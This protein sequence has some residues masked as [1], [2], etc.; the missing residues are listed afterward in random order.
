MAKKIIWSLRAIEDRKN[1][2]EYWRIRNQSSAYSKKL[3]RKFR[4]AVNVL[5]S[6]PKIGRRTDDVKIRMKILNEYLI[7]YEETDDSIQILTIFDSRQAPD[8]LEILLK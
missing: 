8:K 1:I 3:D 7:F 2:L 5:K 4:E 6:F